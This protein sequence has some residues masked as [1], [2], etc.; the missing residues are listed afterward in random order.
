MFIMQHWKQILSNIN[1]NSNIGGYYNCSNYTPSGYVFDNLSFKPCYST[2][3]ECISI[4]DNYN[5][6][7]SVCIDN[8]FLNNGNCYKNCNYYYYFDDFN[9]H[10]CTEDEYCLYNKNKLIEDRGQCI[11]DCSKDA[12]YLYEYD[13]KCYNYIIIMNISNNYTQGNKS[14]AI[15]IAQESTEKPPESKTSVINN[16]ID[17]SIILDED[18]D[19]NIEY[20]SNKLNN[21]YIKESELEEIKSGNDLILIE[22]NELKMSLTT[23]DN[24]INQNK[25]T[26][27]I[28]LGECENKLK[29]FYNISKNESLLI[30]KVEVIKKDMKKARIEY[31]VYYPSNENKLYKLDLNIC[32]EVN[33]IISNPMKLDDKNIDKYNSS[34]DFYKDICYAYTTENGTNMILNDRKE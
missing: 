30:L 22:N 12:L 11:E 19:K 6:Q 21:S 27:K 29:E 14:N 23:S 15:D 16:Y 7:C 25:N 28:D 18:N 4:G 9:I 26:S 33:I 1:Y 32:E 2:C 24:K 17:E 8:Y 10:H 13:N 5:H 20:M 3:K 34:S 31:E